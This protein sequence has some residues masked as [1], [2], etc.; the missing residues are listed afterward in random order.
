MLATLEQQSVRAPLADS[1][2]AQRANRDA[3]ALIQHQRPRANADARA[4]A[5]RA[6]HRAACDR[7]GK[8]SGGRPSR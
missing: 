5:L 8:D 4:S 7:V 2:C 3:V 1:L 6:G